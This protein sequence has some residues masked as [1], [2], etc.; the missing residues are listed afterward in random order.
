VASWIQVVFE[1]LQRRHDLVFVD[2]RGTGKSAPLDCPDP[3]ELRGVGDADFDVK[4]MLQC[5]A[6]LEKL[7]Y[8]D[9]RFFTTTIAM[10]DL[11]AVRAL[12]NYNKID[13]IGV[14]YGT[15]AA[16]EYQ[17][18]FPD[19][20]RR[21]VLD[22]VVQP[23]QMLADDDMQR[24]LN[25]LFQ[26]CDQDARC[27]KTYPSLHQDWKDLLTSLPQ[28]ATLTH[29]RLGTTVKAT[30]TRDDVLGWISKVAYSPVTTS[31]LPH[32][33][34]QAKASNFNPLLA[35]SGTGSLPN[36]GSIAMGM[37]F[38]VVCAEEYERLLKAPAPKSDND[39][40]DLHSREYVKICKQWP[41]GKVPD[42]FYSIPVSKTPVLLLSGGIDPV[43][44]PQHAE[45]VAGALGP[46]ARHIVL[47][48]SGHG[49]L[50]QVCFTDVATNFINT[51][52]DQQ[53]VNVDA[54]C[55]RQIPRPG[56]WIAPSAAPIAEVKK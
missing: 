13:L 1:K 36:P 49:V 52:D 10:Q 47:N 17:R 43:T 21:S 55:V 18:L 46:M 30:V 34:E 31:A 39:F 56:V 44:P 33:I 22:G 28:A 35:L 51:K 20:V 8:G 50:Q 16:L 37:H 53:A 5:K 23:D 14:S 7:P 9:L 27:H 42:G 4:Q 2:Q 25:K 32:A 3:D 45:K 24:T 26:D 15:R 41:E 11:D 38:S 40:G 19:H 6:L 12:L 29:P 54:S 48:N